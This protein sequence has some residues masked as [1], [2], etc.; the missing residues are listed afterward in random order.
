MSLAEIYFFPY[1]TIQ[2]LHPYFSIFVKVLILEVHNKW[3][4]L[5]I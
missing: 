2:N 3:N 5:K 4:I 1:N